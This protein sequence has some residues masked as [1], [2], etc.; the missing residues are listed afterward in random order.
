[1]EKRRGY[2]N[3]VKERGLGIKPWEVKK[4][5]VTG[6]GVRERHAVIE[7]ETAMAAEASARRA[8]RRDF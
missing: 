3:G 8:P 5:C 4:L 1:M 7:D 2:I 6:C